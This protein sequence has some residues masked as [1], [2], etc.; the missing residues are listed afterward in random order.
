[1]A[2]MSIDGLAMLSLSF[3]Q[4]AALP[5]DVLK[6]MAKAGGE[7]AAK[8]QSQK[9]KQMLQGPYYS[10]A[11]AGAT[12]VTKVSRTN[13]GAQAYVTFEGSSHGNTI[14]E[15]AFVNEYGKKRQPARP[16]IQTANE[17]A[18]DDIL[19]AQAEVYNDWLNSENL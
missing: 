5:D 19:N 14:A 18:A 11:V 10:G 15:I 1:M 4:M 9:A 7:V 6:D 8:A 3:D 17:E 12:R 13:D 16:F 2:S